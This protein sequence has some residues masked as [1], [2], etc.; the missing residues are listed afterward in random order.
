MIPQ[1]KNAKWKMV[2][3][4]TADYVSSLIRLPSCLPRTHLRVAL[5]DGWMYVTSAWEGGQILFRTCDFAVDRIE[6]VLVDYAPG[7]PQEKTRRSGR[8]RG[9]NG[10]TPLFE[11]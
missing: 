1:P 9:S 10:G 11:D 5:C 3:E 7:R 8:K 4:E 6:F 2:T